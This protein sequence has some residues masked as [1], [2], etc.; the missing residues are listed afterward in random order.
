M[1][2][3]IPKK[4]LLP[5]FTVGIFYGGRLDNLSGQERADL[6]SFKVSMNLLELIF[7][8]DIVFYKRKNYKCTG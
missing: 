7:E 5:D 8:Y 6:M 3:I 4:D 1:Q 2:Q